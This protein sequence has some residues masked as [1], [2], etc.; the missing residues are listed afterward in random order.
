M[1][2]NS[3]LFILIFILLAIC[4]FFIIKISIR[5]KKIF[6]G[7][8]AE[9]LEDLINDIVTNVEFLNNKVQEHH[10]R[11]K[12]QS[13]RISKQGHGVK[14]AR[15]NPFKDVGGNQ[16]F[17]VAI[18]NEDG[19]GVVLSSLYSRERMSVFAKPVI[20]GTSDIELSDEE[21]DVIAQAQKST[22]N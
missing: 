2:T 7:R 20:S 22:Q 6:K 19:D 10:E 9:T 11:I 3:I 5:L 21:K 15:F 8:K 4:F 17:A 14:I 12:N 16:S 18:V 13:S 1:R